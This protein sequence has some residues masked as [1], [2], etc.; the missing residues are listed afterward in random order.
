MNTMDGIITYCD[1]ELLIGAR[2]YHRVLKREEGAHI[3][4][5]HRYL[6]TLVRTFGE[7]AAYATVDATAPW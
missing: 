4:T 1:K 3:S 5:S 6:I 7:T 2:Y